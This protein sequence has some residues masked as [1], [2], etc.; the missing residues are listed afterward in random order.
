MIT[1]TPAT[2]GKTTAALWNQTCD[3][4]WSDAELAA[5]APRCRRAAPAARISE[6]L[7]PFFPE[8]ERRGRKPPGGPGKEGKKW[9]RSLAGK[10]RE[11]MKS[12]GPSKGEEGKRERD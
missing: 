11:P 8:R 3:P 4:P 5:Q 2:H 10:K 1:P 6:L 12:P 9:E 7:P